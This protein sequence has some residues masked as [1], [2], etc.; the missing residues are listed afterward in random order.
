MPA[1]KARHFFSLKMFWSKLNA[2]KPLKKEN[3]SYE[4]E[5]RISNDQKLF[6]HMQHR[7]LGSL[8][9]FEDK[10][11]K[12]Y[13]SDKKDIFYRSERNT[14]GTGNKIY[15]SKKLL[16]KDYDKNIVMKFCKE[17]KLKEVDLKSHGH[18]RR[19]RLTYKP[20]DLHFK[21]DATVRLFSEILDLDS[22]SL[23][24]DFVLNPYTVPGFK[25]SLDL[26]FEST[27]PKLSEIKSDYEI[28]KKWID[29]FTGGAKEEVKSEQNE[30]KSEQN[31][32]KS[33]QNE[34]TE[35]QKQLVNK[36]MS[37]TFNF[38]Y[39]PQVDI[40]TNTIKE[41]FDK[42]DFY[43]MDKMDGL[44]Q[45]LI[46][47]AGKVY[48]YHPVFGLK[49]LFESN[50]SE[51]S[52][53]DS[54]EVDNSFIIFDVYYVLNSDIRQLVFD[55]RMEK[56]FKPSRLFGSNCKNIKLGT[57]SKINDWGKLIDY[58]S[59]IH[60][61]RDGVV[62]HLNKGYDQNDWLSDP[63]S[64][65]LKPLRYN[66]TDFI[67]KKLSDNYYRLYLIGVSSDLV[68][69]QRA[70]P[71]YITDYNYD[72]KNLKNN[73]SYK[74]LFESPFF[75]C[76][77]EYIVNKDD[78]DKLGES[79][80]EDDG[81]YE[82]YL[83]EN[84]IWHPVR[85]RIDKIYPNGNS[86]GLTNS[87]LNFSPVSEKPIYF[88]QVTF[89]N[90]LKNFKF[91]T[92]DEAKLFVKE[93]KV[94]NNE[95]KSQIFETLKQEINID[96]KN[97]SNIC[98]DIGG[99]RGEDS[100]FL[101]KLGYN[102]FFVQDIDKEAL[103]AYS[104]HNNGRRVLLNCFATGIDKVND[105]ISEVK[106]R[107]EFKPFKLYII[108]FSM[109]YLIKDIEKLHKFIKAT[110]TNDC[111]I[112]ITFHDGNRIKLYRNKEIFNIVTKN[113]V[114]S[115]PAPLISKSGYKKEQLITSDMFDKYFKKIYEFYPYQNSKV[116][117]KYCP[118]YFGCIKSGLYELIYN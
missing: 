47:Y 74:I 26:E 84:C 68:F 28:L 41:S 117:S 101:L 48:K 118:E 12:S 31:E 16:A 7:L 5:F 9:T 76:L 14:N 99:G 60:P 79:E 15:Q 77:S 112:L 64:F 29:K 88:E 53:V 75:R 10:I 116:K 55:K 30:V 103:I 100:D 25:M 87:S 61:H 51:T 4:V 36:I 83:D 96:P 32:V 34:D 44:R 98:C 66:T 18:Y 8:S 107:Q 62:L 102:N 65:K 35:M 39:C 46:N 63:V 1:S 106:D 69:N 33:E 11:I 81:I 42:S 85:H 23:S 71:R 52:I 50:I 21:V 108:N 78:L 80:I 70:R 40:L 90:L 24:D 113:G 105:L 27:N 86:V 115:M 94:V 54:E 20:Y 95:I 13:E 2:A 73:T 22:V 37:S 19:L 57:Y 82:S 17:T 114:T 43:W 72:M 111:R 92:T 56:A 38:K 89:D 91:K 49:F 110:S 93:F 67:Y 6:V 3:E 104:R 97:N 58:A 45:L 109:Q 59:T